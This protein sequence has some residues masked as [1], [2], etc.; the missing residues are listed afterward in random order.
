MT[1]CIA[2]VCKHESKDMFVI[3]TDHM[4][5]VG[6]GQ[7]EHDIKKHKKIDNKNMIA[8]LSGNAL[9]FNELISGI[10]TQ[11]NFED[12]KNLIYNNFINKKQDW[13]KKELLSK[14]NLSFEDIKELMMGR[15]QMNTFTIKLVEQVI[16]AELQTSILLVGCENGKN[17]I[18]EINENGIDNY[19]D[20]HFHA[21]GSGS[22]QA[23]NTLLFQKQSKCDDLRTTIY[24]IYKSK[25]NSEVAV[26]VGRDTDI[27]ILNEKE[28]IELTKENLGLLDKIYSDELSSGKGSKE[29]EKINIQFTNK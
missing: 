5:S 3:A 13:I 10:E 4:I 19:D 22:M 28:V 26:G 29:L 27:L 7:F 12:I 16:K 17:H 15:A 20:I 6:I 8:M 23:A 24:N 14:F 9:I 18:A 25:R 1:I 21:I 11:H 2:A